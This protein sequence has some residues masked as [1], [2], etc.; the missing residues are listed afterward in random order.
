MNITE[1]FKY[2]RSISKEVEFTNLK[3]EVIKCRTIDTW[4]L[5]LSI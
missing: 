3:G 2:A 5:T 1:I 4:Q